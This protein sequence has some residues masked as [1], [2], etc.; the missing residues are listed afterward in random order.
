MIKIESKAINRD[1]V[2]NRTIGC[3]LAEWI[4]NDSDKVPTERMQEIAD[5]LGTTLNSVQFYNSHLR[6][7]TEHRLY[8]DF[9][10]YALG[11]AEKVKPKKAKAQKKPAA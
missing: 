8:G 4:E 10:I 2:K 5:E 9:P 6:N 7:R 11:E 3:L 1:T